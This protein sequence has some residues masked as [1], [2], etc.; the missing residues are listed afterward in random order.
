LRNA[1][2]EIGDD[3]QPDPLLQ[4]PCCL[5]D[6]PWK[7]SGAA[8]AS[9]PDSAIACIMPLSSQSCA[10]TSA[11]IKAGKKPEPEYRGHTSWTK[12]AVNKRRASSSNN[13]ARFLGVTK[14]QK[15]AERIDDANYVRGFFL[16]YENLKKARRLKLSVNRESFCM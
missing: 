1:A 4:I 2:A 6:R 15:A 11:R 7:V 16:G 5:Q 12:S 14:R 3:S 10:A 13:Y 8:L 9:T